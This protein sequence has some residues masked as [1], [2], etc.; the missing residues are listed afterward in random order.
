VSRRLQISAA[1]VTVRFTPSG[2][3]FAQ[4]IEIG[5]ETGLQGV[6]EAVDEWPSA[7]EVAEAEVASVERMAA[8]DDWPPSPPL[9]DVHLEERPDGRQLALMVGRAGASHWS[10]SC[11]LAPAAGELLF[12]VACRIKEP[13]PWLGST[14]QL[15]SGVAYHGDAVGGELLCGENLLCRIVAAANC[16][17]VWNEDARGLIFRPVV[18]AEELGI[19]SPGSFPRTIRWGYKLEFFSQSIQA[20]RGAK[21]EF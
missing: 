14:Y 5:S 17:V 13:A 10:I 18:S 3:R 7:A 19:D 16:K 21:R 20:T 4:R 8:A 1:G 2:D 9:Q 12:D 6:L 15:P 11:E